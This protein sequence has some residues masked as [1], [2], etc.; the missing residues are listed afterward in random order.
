MSSPF[1]TFTTA[2]FTLAF[3]ATAEVQ[4]SADRLLTFA[5][6][7]RFLDLSKNTITRLVRDKA[8]RPATGTKLLRLS[9]LQAYGK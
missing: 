8:L 5:E 2:P 9:Q 1:A 4:P 3:T 7:G 6:A